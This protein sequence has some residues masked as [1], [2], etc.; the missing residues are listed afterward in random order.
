MI[1]VT[2]AT[3]SKKGTEVIGYYSGLLEGNLT[4]MLQGRIPR[5]EVSDNFHI[6]PHS[7]VFNERVQACIG[8]P[9]VERARTWLGFKEIEDVHIVEKE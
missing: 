5:M 6:I 8:V 3:H 9:S 2:I 4:A 7:L 1:P